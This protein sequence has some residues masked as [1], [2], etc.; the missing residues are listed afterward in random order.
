[1]KNTMGIFKA[2]AANSTLPISKTYVAAAQLINI[3][4]GPDYVSDS[5][6]FGT[7]SSATT[8]SLSMTPIVTLVVMFVAALY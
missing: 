1:M 3:G 5:I 4:C 2:S 7:T 6:D 8:F